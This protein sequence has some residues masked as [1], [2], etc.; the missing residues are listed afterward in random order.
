MS[1]QDCTKLSKKDLSR[2]DVWAMAFGCMVGWGSFVMP[3]STFLPVA[4]PT[5]TIISMAIGLA[6]MLVIG[7]CISYIMTRSSA[8]GGIYVY[9]KEAL[10]RDHAFLC[11]WFLS[12]SYLTIVFLNGTALFLV[13]RAM[14]GNGAYRG[15][16]YTIAGKTVYVY[17]VLLS[18][19]ALIGV[20]L[21]FLVAR[22]A[23]KRLATALAIILLAGIAITTA[24][25]LPHA[26]WHDIFGSF[27]Y[28]NVNLGFAIF[29]LVILA[30]WAFVGFEVITFDTAHFNFPIKKTKRV[31]SSSIIIAALAYTFMTLVS[32]SIIPDGYN[33]WSAYI[34]DLDN[35]NGIIS[36]PSFYAA[37]KTMGTFGLFVIGITALAAILTGII[38]AYRAIIN[39]LST[40]AEDRILSQKFAKTKYCIFFVMFLS[41]I[42]SFL[43]RNTLGWFVD[44]TAFGA[45]VAYG[46][47]SL[48]AY[49][50][51][52]TK[53]NLRIMAAGAVGTAISIL[54]GIAQIVPRFVALDAMSCEAFLFLSLWCLLGFIF[55][56]RTVRH[57]SLAEYNTMAT[58]GLVLFAMLLYCAMMWLGKLLINQ[59]TL[60]NVRHALVI[61]GIILMAIV[62]I[63]LIVMLYIQNQV[64]KMHE[65]SARERIRISEGSLARSQFLLNMSHD[66]RTPMNA[67]IGYT[68]L[69]QKEPDYMLRDYLKKIELSGMQL[70]KTLNDILEM[71]KAESGGKNEQEY[72]PTDLCLSFEMLNELFQDEMKQKRIGFSV[73]TSVQNRYVWCNKKVLRQLLWD[74]VSNSCKT[75]PKGGTISASVSET[76]NGENGYSTY[77]MRI[78]NSI[79]SMSAT[80]DTK[81]L[82]TEQLS[83][84]N[85]KTGKDSDIAAIK[86]TIEQMG[87]A[88]EVFSS[89]ENGTEIVIRIKFRLASEKDMQQEITVAKEAGL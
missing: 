31:I 8:S 65:S 39:L 66:I 84:N 9:T 63:G 3:G 83:A 15:Y 38:V 79:L 26:N 7:S 37:R 33:S 46:Y 32:I 43:G 77:E 53:K 12:L 29:S 64:R 86:S 1:E 82:T 41:I 74:I 44:L 18:S 55:Y 34:A 45:I 61:N 27:G 25:C 30:P 80:R 81:L 36:I 35:L 6:I 59:N 57:S 54:F 76:G 16:T 47:T 19:F 67:V 42:V 20:G 10:G 23:L 56:W 52:K 70:Q 5:G 85:D 78:Q 75:T 21:L 49:K 89:P 28:K 22:T 50:I 60:D 69:A 2:L 87:G 62:F 58:S 73:N 48:A 68:K 24:V 72:N 13:I 40:M 17:E 51:A 88:V 71:S 11:A 14:L 4:G